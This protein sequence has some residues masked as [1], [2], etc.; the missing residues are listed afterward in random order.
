MGTALQRMWNARRAEP[1]ARRREPHGR[2]GVQ[3]G[4]ALEPPPW[5]LEPPSG[6]DIRTVRRRMR[7]SRAL[8]PPPWRLQPPTVQNGAAGRMRGAI[9]LPAGA[10]SHGPLRLRGRLEPPSRCDIR[11]VRRRM[12]ASR[13]QD[14][15]GGRSRGVASGRAGVQGREMGEGLRRRRR[16]RSGLLL[17]RRGL[18]PALQDLRTCVKRRKSKPSNDDFA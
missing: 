16:G 13:C 3:I 2:A 10:A 14:A 12:R 15:A 8:E 6:R 9:P 18:G 7:V 11:T 4:R 1:H 17:P 5:R